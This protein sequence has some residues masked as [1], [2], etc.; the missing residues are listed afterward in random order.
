M[1]TRYEEAYKQHEKIRAD[2]KFPDKEQAQRFVKKIREKIEEDDANPK[3]ILTKW[4]VGYY[5]KG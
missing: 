3:I 4:G 5:F 1:N 2:L